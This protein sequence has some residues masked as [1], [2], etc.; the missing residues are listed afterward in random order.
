MLLRVGDD[1]GVGVDE[2][3]RMEGVFGV[4]VVAAGCFSCLFLLLV[5]GAIFVFF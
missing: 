3:L 2:C 1:G 5:E 4:V